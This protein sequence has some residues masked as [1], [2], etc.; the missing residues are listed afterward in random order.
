MLQQE[1]G[2]TWSACVKE[3]TRSHHRTAEA[4]MMPL[5]ERANNPQA[6]G[7]LLQMQYGFYQPLEQLIFPF[8]R[9]LPLPDLFSPRS[10]LI[11]KDLE[12]LQMQP[13]GVSPFLP[14]IKDSFAALGALYVLEGAALG[15]RII[16]RMLAAHATLP[17]A[18]FSFF[19]GREEST[20][21]YW[22]RFTQFLN[23]HVNTAG[24]MQVVGEAASATFTAYTRWM[25]TF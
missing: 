6:Y 14:E 22:T 18:A 5:I 8:V 24:E 7:T 19:K 1:I 13:D 4:V 23:R 3:Q 15:G 2:E 16:A 17:N 21:A 12:V 20:G 10:E 11:Q 9:L 25:Q